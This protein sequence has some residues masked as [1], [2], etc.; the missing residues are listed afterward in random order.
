MTA[1]GSV[2]VLDGQSGLQLIGRYGYNRTPFLR[3]PFRGL[4]SPP[5][6]D[7]VRRP[8]SPCPMNAGVTL[9]S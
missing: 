5:A 7:R 4:L 3:A 9:I 2:T 8:K 6:P 1:I